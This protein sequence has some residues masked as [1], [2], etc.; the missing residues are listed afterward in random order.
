MAFVTVFRRSNGEKVRV[1]QTW[2]K[3]PVLKEPFSSSPV[4]V[5]AEKV[6]VESPTRGKKKKEEGK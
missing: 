6:V 1:P 5:E 4:E 2:M 3:H